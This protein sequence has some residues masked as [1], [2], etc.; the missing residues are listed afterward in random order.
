[1]RHPL[2]SRRHFVKMCTAIVTCGIM[3]ILLRWGR[4]QPVETCAVSFEVVDSETGAKLPALI[5]IV[6]ERGE[7]LDLPE[8]LNRGLGIQ[9]AGMGDQPAIEEWSAL[10]QPATLKLPREKLTISAFS[11]LETEIATQ[12]INLAKQAE[13]TV[14]IPLKRFSRLAERNTFGGNTHLHLMKLSLDTC[15]RYLREISVADDLDLLF[16]SY[17]ERTIANQHYISNR[18]TQRDFDRLTKQTGRIF[19]NGE[20][21][22][23]NFTGGQEGYGHVMFLDLPKLILP[24]SIGPDI[25]KTGD[26]GIPLDRGIQQARGDGATVVWCHNDYGR[27]SIPQYVKGQ[28]DALNIFDGGI[29]SSYKES[30]YRLLNA[31]YRVPF[32]TGTDWFLYDFSRVYVPVEGELTTDNWLAGLKAGRGF[33]TNGPL[34]QFT[35]DGKNVGDELQ[36]DQPGMVHIQAECRCRCDFEMLELIYNGEIIAT[37]KT[38]P[39]EGHFEARIDK[40]MEVPG[41]GWWALRTPPP[42]VKSDP[43]LSVPRPRNEL[44][45]ELY[46]HTSPI[47]VTVNGKPHRDPAAIASLIVHVEESLKYIPANGVYTDNAGR[48][49]ILSLYRQTMEE[50]KLRLSTA[51][52]LNSQR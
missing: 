15:E 40:P 6:N 41:S 49:T 18:Y 39:V 13:T 30:F 45:R 27:E 42:S 23:N 20:E 1:M 9:N 4:T 37:A 47:Y 36:L 26:D 46:S 10:P 3:L 52:A 34:L 28:I 38:Q 50:L 48:E 22:R 12:E 8:L 43:A 29:R 32:S 25:A 33:I 44:G 19:A 7:I 24:V 14:A 2:A 5:K 51:K 11:G 17:L 16:V 21:H 35:V 31:G